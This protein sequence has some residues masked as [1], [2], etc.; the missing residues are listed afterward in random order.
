MMKR[1]ALAAACFAVF[2]AATASAG[3]FTLQKEVGD[4]QVD[5]KM[6]KNPPAVG[7]NHVEVAIKDKAGK[8]VK[9][10]KVLVVASMP[11][12]VVY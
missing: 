4:Y 10:A 7:M 8:A 1:W 5:I 12:M 2:I 9:N 6:D 3:E 11:T